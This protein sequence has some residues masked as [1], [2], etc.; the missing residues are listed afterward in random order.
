MK[1]LT[2]L[3]ILVIILVAASFVEAQPTHIVIVGPGGKTQVCAI[4]EGANGPILV[5]P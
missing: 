1:P 3:V 4:H 2:A 5:C